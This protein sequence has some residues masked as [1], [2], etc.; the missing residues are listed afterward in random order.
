M[1]KAAL[2]TGLIAVP[3]G[4]K[5]TREPWGT[6]GL[7]L[8]F[9]TTV[10]GCW[11]A[12]AS[13]KLF[14]GTKADGTTRRFVNMILGAGVGAASIGLAEWL[15]LPLHAESTTSIFDAS[16]DLLG[17]GPANLAVGLVSFFAAA[18]LVN[19]WWKVADRDRPARLRLWPLLAS[20]AVTL[21]LAPALWPTKAPALGLGMIS[22]I[23]LVTQLVSPW[24]RQAAAFAAYAR[25]N[26]AKAA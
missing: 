13:S 19:G 24:D 18:F 20:G 16:R 2:L 7:A 12:L 23:A 4:L 11:A 17:L 6:E 25:A 3:L 5:L 14:E 21:V 15:R 10:L 8:L 22:T 9:A 26:K 1:V